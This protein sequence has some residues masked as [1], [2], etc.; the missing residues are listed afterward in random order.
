MARTPDIYWLIYCSACKN[1][2]E[3]HQTELK[4]ANINKNKQL[5]EQIKMYGRATFT[6][7]RNRK[8]RDIFPTTA[9]A[10]KVLMTKVILINRGWIVHALCPNYI[11]YKLF[12]LDNYLIFASLF[13]YIEWTKANTSNWGNCSIYRTFWYSR[14]GIVNCNV[15]LLSQLDYKKSP[16][17]I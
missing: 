3:W 15:E 17:Y 14:K 12:K 1:N 5:G 7:M 13:F 16:V 11:R 9:R 2:Q 4:I 6:L 10:Y 8:T